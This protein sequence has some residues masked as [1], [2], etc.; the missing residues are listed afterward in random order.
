L[1]S[2]ERALLGVTVAAVAALAS[3]QEFAQSTS[4]Y[5]GEFPY[6]VDTE[7]QP[8]VEVEGVR[9]RLVRV[10]P[11]NADDVRSGAEVASFVLFD[12]ENVR[13]QD[14]AVS[15]VVLLEDELG[16]PLERIECDPVKVQA[17]TAKSFRHKTKIQGDTLLQTR[18]V[19][20]FCEVER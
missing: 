9:L 7:L 17:A 11:K 8:A 10:T 4:P 16:N 2:I 19:Y 1:R 13:E 14:A 20:L 5:Q 3:A 12:L 18:K 6:A 15:V